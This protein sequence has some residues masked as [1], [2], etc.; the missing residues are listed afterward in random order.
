MREPKFVAL[1][2]WSF[3]P[4]AL[5]WYGRDKKKWKKGEDEKK[6]EGK[7]EKKEQERGSKK[8]EGD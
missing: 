4:I 6:E 3:V 8:N 2:F 7:D 1:G 5:F